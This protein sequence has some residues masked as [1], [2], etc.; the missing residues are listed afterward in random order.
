MLCK[1]KYF[2]T[3]FNESLKVFR[4]EQ[5]LSCTCLRSECLKCHVEHKIILNTD[6]RL[7][8]LIFMIFL[9]RRGQ[10][11]CKPPFGPFHHCELLDFPRPHLQNLVAK[12]LW[13]LPLYALLL[14]GERQMNLIIYLFFHHTGYKYKGLWG[15]FLKCTLLARRTKSPNKKKLLKCVCVC[16]YFIRE[17]TSLDKFKDATV[18]TIK[19][20]CKWIKLGFGQSFPSFMFASCGILLIYHNS[21]PCWI[22]SVAWRTNKLI[23]IDVKL[24]SNLLISLS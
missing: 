20:M 23:K 12:W 18:F 22:F 5:H 24:R 17:W 13:W 19:T 15:H 3:S 2:K 8:Y 4:H 10:I 1:T 21:S 6:I 11:S 9:L 14:T 7:F 16:V